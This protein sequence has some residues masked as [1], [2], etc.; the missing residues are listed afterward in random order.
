[1]AFSFPLAQVGHP[2]CR[3]PRCGLRPLE[4]HG[5]RWRYPAF[6]DTGLLNHRSGAQIPILP[7]TRGCRAGLRSAWDST[8]WSSHSR[9]F[10]PNHT[11]LPTPG[12]SQ[13]PCWL[14]VRGGRAESL[15]DLTSYASN[16]LYDGIRRHGVPKGRICA[17]CNVA[18]IHSRGQHL[19][20]TR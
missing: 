18:R 6:L 19:P 1:M 12:S 14:S 9:R 4:S 20:K 10:F 17:R 13:L 8:G 15:G 2:S 5:S 3:D 16:R 11:L 7:S